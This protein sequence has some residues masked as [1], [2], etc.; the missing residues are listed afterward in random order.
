MFLFSTRKYK[1]S[2]L[3]REHH[4]FNDEKYFDI[5][6]HVSQYRVYI[7]SPESPRQDQCS[8]ERPEAHAGAGGS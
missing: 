3:C 5:S 7:I 8:P 6:N 1:I 4:V 2:S